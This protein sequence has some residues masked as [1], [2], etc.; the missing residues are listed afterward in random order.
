[1]TVSVQSVLDRV[2]Q[3]LQD[4]AG[5]RWSSTNEL[6]LWVND[7][8][9]EIALLKPDAT[10]TNATVALS[11][12]TKQTIPDDGNRLLR[13]VRNMA[14]IEKT[15]TITVV[16]SGGNKFYTDGSFQTLTLEEG[17]TYTF[18]QS[19]SSNNGHPLRFS[20]TA[21]GSHGGGSEYT[22]GVTTSGTPGS[23]TAFTKIT[24][25]IDAPTLYTYC[26][27]HAG[28]G[29]LVLTSTRV[30]TGK[31]ATRLVSRDSLDSIQ[32]SWHDPTVKGDAKHGS[33]IKHYMYEDQNP[34][35]Y[36]VYPGVASGASSFLEIIYSA[37]PATVAANGNLTVPDL[38]ANAIMNY[39]LYM[40]YMKD[41]EFVGS[42]QR[43][44]A[45]Y[46]LF[47][48]SVTGKAQIDLSTSPNAS[49]TPA[50]QAQMG[51]IG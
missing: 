18:D 36:Y 1:M 17:S 15:Y 34:R 24:V 2:Q 11:E 47:I 37:N 8:Q 4:T 40:A 44:S 30:G 48:T 50:P 27:A 5:I 13:V 23:G 38:F 6:V 3:T 45:H 21:N 26:T 42:Q 12:G 33:L 41:S 46:N 22:T 25:G 7:A 19:D 43:A 39:V 35:N 20:T 49:S 51:G 32:P 9:R 10:A 31:R 16:N 14:M 29:F 28:M